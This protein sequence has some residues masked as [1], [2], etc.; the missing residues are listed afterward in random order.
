MLLPQ[1]IGVLK[2]I[3]FKEKESASN[4]V[5]SASSQLL[6][7]LLDLILSSKKQEKLQAQE[8]CLAHIGEWFVLAILLTAKDVV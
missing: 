7:W 5:E 6:E 1:A 4:S 3:I 2:G 8:P